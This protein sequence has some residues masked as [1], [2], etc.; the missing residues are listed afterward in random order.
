LSGTDNNKYYGAGIA[1]YPSLNYLLNK[2]F[3]LQLTLNN[4]VSLG[5]RHSTNQL[6]QPNVP[7]KKQESSNFGFNTRVNESTRLSDLSFAFRY[8]F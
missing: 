5:Y 1:L 7:S 8:I 6:E 4:F 2:K 3:I